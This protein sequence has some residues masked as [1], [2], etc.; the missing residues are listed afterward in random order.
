MD[1]LPRPSYDLTD[2]VIEIPDLH[3]KTSI[4]GVEKKDETWDVSWLQDQVGW[5]NG[6]SY[7][8]LKG[9]SLL[10][11]HVVNAD[12][13]PGIF[14]HLKYLKIG[15]YIFIYTGS[16]RYTYQVKSNQIVKP[17]DISVI[18]H[19]ADS[20]LT[21]LSCDDYDEAL[22]TYVQRVAVRAKL[23]DVSVVK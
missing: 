23:V 21:L 6:T 14:F 13:K 16:Y 3:L 22:G 1:S 4:V 19:E 12:G 5:L 18:E 15:E 11:G 20:Y 17:D 8:T 2:L 10:T 9:N 7:P